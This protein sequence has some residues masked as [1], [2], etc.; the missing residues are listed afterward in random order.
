MPSGA[1]AS[2]G[3]RS[4][5][6]PSARTGSVALPKATE[7]PVDG[8]PKTFPLALHLYPSVTLYDGRGANLSWLQEMPDPITTAVWRN[9]VEVNPKTA[10][11]L[12]LAEGD[13][14]TVTSPSGKITAHVA[15]STS[16]PGCR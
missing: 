12:G 1:A 9:W 6:G 4:P 13:G 16:A 8:D 14:V 3:S 15:S 11:G 2:S 7:R 10:A 5:L